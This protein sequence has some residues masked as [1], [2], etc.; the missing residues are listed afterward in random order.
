MLKTC[1]GAISEQ[2]NYHFG[3]AKQCFEA[4][5]YIFWSNKAM[6]W[7]RRILISEQQNYILENKTLNFLVEYLFLIASF[8][9]S[10]VQ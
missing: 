4:E 6:L 7:S 9:Y 2:V 8:F 10:D 3:A 5:G 1:F